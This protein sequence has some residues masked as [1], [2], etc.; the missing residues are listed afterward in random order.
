MARPALP[1]AAELAPVVAALGSEAFGTALLVWL[2]PSLGAAHATAFRF[3]AGLQARVVM[4]AGALGGA[5][6]RESARVYLG[7]GL[8][9]HD[10][11]RGLIGRVPGS[12]SQAA[13]DGP[14]LLRTRRADI[15]SPAYG[16]ALWDRFGLVDRLSALALVDGQWTA[17]NLYRDAAAGP[18]TPAALRRLARLAPLLMALLG[19]HLALLRPEGDGAATRLS[20][21]AAAALLQRL[22]VALSGRERAV[23]ALT[24]AGQSRPGIA[25]ALGIAPS[26][27]ATL[28]A[29]AYRKLGIHGAG[30]LF[31]LCL[32]PAAAGRGG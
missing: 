19:R 7:S 24:L 11:L 14:V 13:G 27:V 30:E 12:P 16:A 22:P 8:Y 9:R 31:A 1:D 25:L 10:R 3:D 23:C 17:L 5:V 4:A 28:R 29:R 2:M 21:E 6:A 15:A 26:S 20:P 18:F 32:Q